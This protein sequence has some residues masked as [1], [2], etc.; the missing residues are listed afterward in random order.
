MISTNKQTN[1]QTDNAHL[2]SPSNKTSSCNM[3]SRSLEHWTRLAAS[4]M[5]RLDVRPSV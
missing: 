5:S 2:A 4:I 3:S 1:K